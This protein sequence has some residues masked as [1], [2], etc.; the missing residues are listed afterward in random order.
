MRARSIKPGF[1]KNEELATCSAWA[2]LLAPGLWMMADR[3]G[4]MEYRPLRIK[5]EIFPY[6]SVDVDALMGELEA[7]EHIQTFH[8]GGKRF[9]QITKFLKH[10]RPHINESDST[11]PAPPPKNDEQNQQ[12]AETCDH[13]SKHL[14]PRSQ[15]LRSESL[16]IESVSE[17]ISPLPE[18]RSTPE[19]SPP[20][21][22]ESGE[23]FEPDPTEPTPDPL[24]TAISDACGKMKAAHP[25]VRSCGLA[26]I[27]K[28]LQAI[29][30]HRPALD[31]APPGR[32]LERQ[33]WLIETIV[34]NHA[35]WCATEQ[36][37]KD[38][39]EYAKGLGNWLAHTMLLYLGEPPPPENRMAPTNGAYAQ[40]KTIRAAQ[41]YL[42]RRAAEEAEANAG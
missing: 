26:E 27:R 12:V 30:N 28:K 8:H 33:L 5:A 36:W 32:K 14:S 17:S 16:F 40:S 34:R 20:K 19:P 9:V 22:A 21:A 13:G 23:L 41:I 31:H 38:N 39:G 15:A 24:D 35:G 18:V 6:D 29:V 4:R 7:A 1:F 37:R 25:P 11:I 3:E 10:Q 2:R 42:A